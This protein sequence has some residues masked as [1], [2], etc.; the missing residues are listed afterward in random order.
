MKCEKPVGTPTV[1]NLLLYF[2][3]NNAHLKIAH[4]NSY[5]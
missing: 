2:L 5:F 1:T 3:S 4:R